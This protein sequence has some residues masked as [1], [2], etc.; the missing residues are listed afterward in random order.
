MSSNWDRSMET[1]DSHMDRQ[2]REIIE[3]VDGLDAMSAEQYEH[4][5]TS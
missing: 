3:L 1:G 2:H 4:R 5:T